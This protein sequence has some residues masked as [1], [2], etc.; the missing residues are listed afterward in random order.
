MPN[1]DPRMKLFHE[2]E[3]Y[4]RHWIY[5]EAHYLE[6]RGPAKELQL[7]HGVIPV[8]LAILVAV[9]MPDPAD[10]EAVGFGPPPDGQPSWPWSEETFQARLA[11]ARAVLALRSDQGPL[12]ARAR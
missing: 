10:Q 8:D 3:L 9:S 7:Q 2:E 11:E 4:L 5:D 1:K 6:G 12:I